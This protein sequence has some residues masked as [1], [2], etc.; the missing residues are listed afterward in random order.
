MD[1]SYV[2][3][4]VAHN[5]KS[6]RLLAGALKHFLCKKVLVSLF[7]ILKRV[8]GADQLIVGP[9]HIFPQ[10]VGCGGTRSVLGE[11]LQVG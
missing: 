2:A 1:H 6:K 3:E 7:V 10:L 8:H 4:H 5:G 9:L 11:V